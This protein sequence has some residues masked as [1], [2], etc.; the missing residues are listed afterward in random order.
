[1]LSRNYKILFSL[2][3]LKSIL[4][5]F[6]DVF[7]VL[8][9]INVSNN[10]ILPLGI[11]KLVAM[12]TVY[13]VVFLLRNY[14]KSKNRVWLMRIGIILYFI[15]FLAI[16]LLKENVVDYIYL[17][18]LLYGLEEGFYYS[19]YNTIESDGIENKD[20]EKYL[21]SYNGYKNIV[22]IIFPLFFGGLIQNSGFINTIIFV[23]VIVVLEIILSV[24]L[25]DNNI[26]K[27]DKTNLKEF[28]NDMK[29]HPELKS[30]IIT[31]ICSGLTYSEGALSYVITIYII[32]VFSE[33]V[34]LGIFTSIFSAISI[35]I[36]FLFANVIKPKYYIKLL[37]IS[38]PITIVL[39]CIMLFDCNFITVVLYNLFQ[40][41]SRLLSDLIKERNI[42]NFSNIKT[43]KKEYKVEYFLTLETALFI[44]R[45]ISNTLFI[46][47]AFLNARF[48][49]AIFVLF[50]ILQAASIIKLQYD[51]NKCNAVNLELQN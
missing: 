27:G 38:L 9:F 25:K 26:P 20:R 19:V 18:G 28:K 46:L 37:G 23:L 50:V 48:I 15:Y 40:T 1:M 39:L 31:N 29:K 24:M 30:I 11:Y 17:I 2:R 10:N 3:L 44:G 36:V 6:V 8:Y 49:M 41:I 47:M 16:I 14:C 4:T 51:M 45:V 7:L 13:L 34:S 21:G 22:S 33:S 32:K 5:S 35:I 42:F 43:I 12:V